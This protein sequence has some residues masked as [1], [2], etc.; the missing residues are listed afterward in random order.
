VA[1]SF[2]LLYNPPREQ[3]LQGSEYVLM[4][5]NLGSSVLRAAVEMVAKGIYGEAFARAFVMFELGQVRDVKSQGLAVGGGPILN[6]FLLV[7]CLSDVEK[8]VWWLVENHAVLCEER[9]VF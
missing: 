8:P 4:C 1:R 9:S 5:A 6:H 7:E 3:P 2:V